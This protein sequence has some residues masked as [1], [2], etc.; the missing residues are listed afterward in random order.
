M[1]AQARGHAQWA[2]NMCVSESVVDP[3]VMF[4]VEFGLDCCI[5]C[6]G[7]HARGA[8]KRRWQKCSY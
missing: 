8:K 5:L 6:R 1:G 7:I 2:P 3:R 4:S